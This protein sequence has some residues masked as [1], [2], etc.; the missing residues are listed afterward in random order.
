M[1]VFVRAVPVLSGAILSGAMLS[2][3]VLGAGCA[4]GGGG[5]DTD[6]PA[7]FLEDPG[8]PGAA[9]GDVAAPAVPAASGPLES[10]DTEFG[11]GAAGM[12]AIAPLDAAPA[13]AA[14][15]AGAELGTNG[16]EP[17]AC[18]ARVADASEVVLLGDSWWALSSIH[19]MLE[20]HTGSKY[21]RTH[22]LS[23]VSMTFPNAFGPPIPTQYDAAK[24][25]GPIKT[26]I[27]DGGGNDVLLHPSGALSFSPCY[28]QITAECMRTIE[29]VVATYD[30]LI[31]R[32]VADGVQDIVIFYYGYLP[33]S[34]YDAVM[35]LGADLGRVPCDAVEACH[36]VDVRDDFRGHETQYIGIDG[37]HPTPAGAQVVADA[38]AEVL[39]RE[40]VAYY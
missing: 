23:G 3:A 14:D 10:T 13:A 36:F 12:G 25:A 29:D 35:D 30:T 24:V 6:A 11:M 31:Q 32:M 28:G 1:N 16:G 19:P 18:A 37:I 8:S 39:A 20:A 5:A 17:T 33:D 27:M 21:T 2:A 9:V 40:C 15:P 38:I 7:A 34:N 4:A 22:Y 26:V